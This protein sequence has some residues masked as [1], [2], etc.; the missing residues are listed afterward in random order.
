M[1]FQDGRVKIFTQVGPAAQG[2]EQAMKS[3]LQEKRETAVTLCRQINIL[4]R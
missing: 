4:E 2:L 3:M 1:Q